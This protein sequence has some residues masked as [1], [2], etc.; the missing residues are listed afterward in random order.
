MRST[1]PRLAREV[2]YPACHT[3]LMEIAEARRLWS[4]E[5]G[6]LNTASFGLPPQPAWEAWQ[7]ALEDWRSGRTSWEGWGDTV[8]TARAR[9]ARMIGVDAA[10]VS[11]GAQVSQM[12]APVA[13]GL[14][15][16]ATV[17]LP[18]IEFTS[19][20]YPWAVHADRGVTVRTAPVAK[21][22]EQLDSDIDVV[23]FSLVQSANGE[24]ADLAGIVAAARDCGA[25]VVVDAT[26]ACGWLPFA[27]SQ[28]DVV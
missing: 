12:L 9:F 8:E 28:A 10:D 11:V 5:P 20:V 27:A 26:Q 14:P 25:T 1:R 21:L 13:A 16:G 3:R 4:A 6:W 19:N 22:A 24:I 7:V 23:A 17:L 15:D 18:D 2:T